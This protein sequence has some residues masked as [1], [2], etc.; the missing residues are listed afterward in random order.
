MTALS[1][2]ADLY[3]H[4]SLDTTGPWD[5][6]LQPQRGDLAQPQ[7]DG[8]DI[9]SLGP[10]LLRFLTISPFFRVAYFVLD[11]RPAIG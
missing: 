10:K 11:I 5:A 7:R 6:S 1:H 3:P 9:S 8:R 2:G 4:F